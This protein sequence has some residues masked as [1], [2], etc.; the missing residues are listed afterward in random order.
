MGEQGSS[1][2]AAGEEGRILDRLVGLE[3]VIPP[4]LM[5][6][7]LLEAGRVNGRACPLTPRRA[8]AVDRARDG[9]VHEHAD[10]PGVS[11]FAADAVGR[12]V[13]G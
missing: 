13:P 10:S 1:T 8:G 5:R 2:L 12:Q 4:E 7:V 3:K 6:Q 11:S 9:S